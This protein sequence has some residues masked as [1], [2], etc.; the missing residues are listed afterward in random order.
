MRLTHCFI[1]VGSLL[2]AIGAWAAT[3]IAIPHPYVAYLLDGKPVSN[4]L[5]SSRSSLT[6]SP[7]PH[8]LVI[9]FEGTFKDQSE[10]RLLSGEPVV[11]NLVTKQDQQLA[12]EFSYPR[13][14]S[15][16]EQYLKQQKL[17]FIDQSTGHAVKADYFVMPK[18]EGLQIGRNYQE[19]LIAMGKAFAQPAAQTAAP[20][21]TAQAVAGTAAVAAAAQITPQ[22]TAKGQTLDK[23]TQALEML[24][25]WYNQANGD[26]RKAFQY[27]VISQQ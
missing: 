25:Y 7:G 24:K 23:N 18:K 10:S 16:A 21:A 11:I 1:G 22:T 13:S 15:A 8:Q 5:F 4:D 20:Q 9:R 2:F 6:L 27:W 12:I 3:A 14:Y 17:Q 19:E 26:T